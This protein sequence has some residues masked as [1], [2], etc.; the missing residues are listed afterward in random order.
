MAGCILMVI[1][2]YIK[3]RER[4]I[5]VQTGQFM[6]MALGNGILGGTT[7]SVTNLIS[8][9]RNFLVYKKWINWPVKI[10]IAASF[11][12][13]GLAFNNNG[14]WGILPLLATVPYTLLM[15]IKSDIGLK[16]MLMATCVPWLIYDLH[17]MN[18]AALPFDAG[19]IIS[20]CIGIYRIKKDEGTE[21]DKEV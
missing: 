2:G 5:A 11:V 10:L 21:N 6:L 14:L 18:Y 9:F 4:V 20:S 12:G 16:V 13:R 7:G 3:K 19:F 1:V 8:A 17:L 15:D